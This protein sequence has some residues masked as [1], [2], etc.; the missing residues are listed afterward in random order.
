MGQGLL[1]EDGLFTDMC[2]DMTSLEGFNRLLAEGY[3]LPLIPKRTRTELDVSEVGMAKGDYIGSQLEKA[4][5]KNEI[6]YAGLKEVVALG[7]NRKAWLIFASGIDHA[8]HIASILTQ[9]GIDC[10][11]VHSR[12]K[13]FGKNEEY[14]DKAIK[15][16]KAGT[17]RSIVCYSK[18][19]V[20]F[21]NPAIDLIADFRPTMSTVLHIQKYCRGTRPSSSTG[22]KNCLVLDFSRNIPRLGCVNDPIIPKKKGNKEGDVPVKI[23]EACGTYNHLKVR[24]CTNCGNEFYFQVKITSKPSVD[25]IIKSDFPIVET[26]EVKKANYTTYQKSERPKI[27]K[28]TYDAGLHLF[29]EYICFEHSGYPKKKAHDWWRQRSEK[30]CPQTTDEAF[31]QSNELRVPKRLKVW[32]NK[33]FPEIL[34]YEF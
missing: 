13:D 8:E 5:D 12:Q 29:K 4:V 32:I 9:F 26:Y 21:D 30:E 22:K 27:L 20:G 33:R 10:A 19:T 17:L 16:F 1:I 25:E 34:S 24:Y 15:A 11:A 28:V 23:C 18:L 2:Y 6:T 14:N 31:K 7:Q 3:M